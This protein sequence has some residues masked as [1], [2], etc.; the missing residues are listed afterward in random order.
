MD[1][2]TRG[3]E[4]QGTE[5][6]ALRAAPDGSSGDPG[7]QENA[8]ENEGRPDPKQDQAGPEEGT[9]DEEAPGLQANVLS[10]CITS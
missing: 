5:G 8:E 2:W 6:V 7:S 10:T 9:P 3:E 1:P 4:G